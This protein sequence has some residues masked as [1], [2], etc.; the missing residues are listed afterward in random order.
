MSPAAW[1]TQETRVAR[2]LVR[3]RG[4]G[5]LPRRRGGGDRV[6]ARRNLCV[7]GWL[8][9]AACRGG[10]P[11]GDSVASSA[12]AVTARTWGLAYLQANQL[13]QAEAEFEKVVKLA[14]DQAV[15]YA[16]LGLVYLREGRYREAEAQLRRAAALDSAD[17]NI[18]LMLARVY[19]LTGREAEARREVERVLRRDSTDIRALYALAELA[20]RSSDPEGP[21]RQESYLRQVVTRAPA[22]IAAR[23]ELVELLLARAATDDAAAELEALQ[24]QLP[25]P[26]PDAP[27]FFQRALR[28]AR[29]GGSRAS[30][31]GAPAKQFHR[32]ME[33]T[34]AYQASLQRLGG[35]SAPLVGYPVLTFNQNIAVPTQDPR[36]V[37]ADIR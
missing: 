7:V 9:A 13:P 12:A 21:Q 19:E 11:G 22:N 32:A 3:V 23:L 8:L 18:G 4:A 20:G 17:S 10:T 31:A 33:V 30:E 15:G 34:A 29:A 6:G 25:Q 27:R 1:A 14:P 37:A 35:P 2:A 36:A 5:D 24:R 28:A 26:P 16:D